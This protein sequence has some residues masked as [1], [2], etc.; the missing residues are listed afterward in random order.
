MLHRLAVRLG[1]IS[2]LS[3]VALFSSPSARVQQPDGAAQVRVPGD[4][5]DDDARL[6]VNTDLISFHVTVT[7][8]SG[9]CVAALPRSAFTVLDGKQ[10]QEIS[11]FGE[12]DSPVTVGIVFDLTG[13]MSDAKLGRAR[14]A[15]AHF[16]ET[17]HKDDDYYLVTLEGG[18]VAIPLAATRDHAAV[19][20]M[21][22]RVVPHGQTALYDACY[23]GVSKVL[24]GAHRR[25]A[26]LLISDGLDNNS[27]YT[28][29][30][31]RDLLTESD[32][33]VYAIS[34]AEKGND[35]AT[36]R[37]DKI[38][39]DI[40]AVT[41][42]KFFQPGS[43]EEMYEVFERIALELRRQYT[44][45]YRPSGLAADGRWH[46][47]KVKLSPPPGSPRLFARYRDGYYAPAAAVRRR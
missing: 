23:L 14:E 29:D 17:S 39:R 28:F 46:S 6:V 42:G 31:L 11:F 15:L 32:V 30:E 10:A 2:V 44:I 41:G 37:A 22:D 19:V 12:D 47:L 35:A 33:N 36:V 40:S 9:R 25:R 38:L 24:R 20:R 13:S 4:Y 43:A 45:A 16:M 5:A 34:V 7:D 8:G 3:L 26:L 1:L 27:V 21:L 18:G